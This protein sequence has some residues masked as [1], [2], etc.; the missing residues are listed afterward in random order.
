MNLRRDAFPSTGWL[1]GGHSGT[2]AWFVATDHG[3]R[4]AQ[5]LLE[6]DHG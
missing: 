6:V 1:I 2:Q 5:P 3:Y 4:T